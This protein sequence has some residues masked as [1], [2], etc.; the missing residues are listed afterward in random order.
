[1]TRMKLREPPELDFEPE[2]PGVLARMIAYI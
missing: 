2:S 1:M